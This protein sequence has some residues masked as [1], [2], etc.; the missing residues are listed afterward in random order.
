MYINSFV[1][2]VSDEEKFQ[3]ILDMNYKLGFQ[4]VFV[5]FESIADYKTFTKSNW[6]KIKPKLELPLNTESITLFKHKKPNI[7][8]FPRITILAKN[9]QELKQKLNRLIH[10]KV[11]ISVDSQNQQVLEVAARDGRVDLLN[12]SKI[13][14]IQNLTKGIISL[15]KQNRCYL[16]LNFTLIMQQNQYLH[17]RI[18]R[19]IYRLFIDA[20]PNSHL[21]SIGFYKEIAENLWLLRGPKE[22]IAILHTLFNIPKINCKQMISKNNEKIAL[23]EIKRIYDLFIEPNVEI[24]DIIENKK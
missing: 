15:A 13:E 18:L 12:L 21:Y 4:A 3:K 19:S 11:I 16:D 20:P 8:I 17:S 24:I 5:N 23:R 7:A 9:P 22:I 10:N 6:C 1:P 2:W 14:N